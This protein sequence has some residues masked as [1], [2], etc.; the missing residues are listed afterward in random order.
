MYRMNNEQQPLI[1][2]VT[3]TFNS[4]R[5]LPD[6]LRSLE[7]Q[8]YENFRLCAVDNVSTDDTVA[9][10]RAWNDPRLDLIVNEANTGC[11]AGNNRGIAAALAAGCEYIL[12]LNND[13][14][15]GPDLIEGLFRGII[16]HNCSMT[17][18]MIYYA[19]P[20]NVIWSAGGTFREDFAFLSIHFGIKE[21][22]R[23]QFNEA[24]PVKFS[25]FACTLIKCEVIDKVGPM[26]ETFFVAADDT[27]F[28]YR[29]MQAG[30]ETYYLPHVKMWHKV[31]SITGDDSPLLQR[32]LARSRA[33]FIRKHFGVWTSIRFTVLYRGYYL[34]RFL[35]GKDDWK[36]LLRKERAWSEGLSLRR[37]V[38]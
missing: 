29:A 35:T 32:F 4:G 22:D 8:T 31:S 14:F 3:V 10:L 5:L 27:D 16:E 1:G 15:F 24:K 28:M 7:T 9:Q 11:A 19:E 12:I 18:P 21:I 30:F 26:D 13:V 36:T 2:I 33:Y 37:S 34:S 23:G 38:G 17:V 6:F 20:K 25:P